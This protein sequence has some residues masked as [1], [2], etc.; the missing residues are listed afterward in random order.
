M[1]CTCR[2]EPRIFLISSIKR[3]ERMWKIKQNWSS[4]SVMKM[5]N[6]FVFTLYLCS[7]VRYSFWFFF[8]F[9]FCCCWNFDSS[10]TTHWER[11]R[12]RRCCECVCNLFQILCRIFPLLLVCVY[13]SWIWV[14]TRLDTIKI[15]CTDRA[16]AFRHRIQ[17]SNNCF[18]TVNSIALACN[19]KILFS[20]FFYFS[21][22]TFSPRN[23]EFPDFSI[24]C[25]NVVFLALS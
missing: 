3:A 17:L 14:A 22:F 20:I 2:S 24:R 9:Y 12:G 15:G 11:E 5:S 4:N 19:R 10:M 13:G 1:S 23:W 7:H 16:F 25:V 8:F 6:F 21:I 18:R